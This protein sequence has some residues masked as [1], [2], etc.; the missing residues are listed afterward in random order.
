MSV[1]ASVE[2]IKRVTTHTNIDTLKLTT[3]RGI[4]IR[5]MTET[6]DSEGENCSL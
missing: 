5:S 2:I 3:I 4:V 1:L 6:Y